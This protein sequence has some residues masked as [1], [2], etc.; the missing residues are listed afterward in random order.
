VIIEIKGKGVVIE[1]SGDGE[2][3][4][5]VDWIRDDED[6]R[7]TEACV[8]DSEDDLFDGDETVDYD[9][10]DECFEENVAKETEWT[11]ILQDVCEGEMRFDSDDHTDGDSGDE[12]DSE[13]NSN[14]ENAARA[15]VFCPSD[16]FDPR[17][18]LGMKFSHKK[19]FREAVHSHAI[20]TRRNLVITKNDKRRVYAR[21]KSNGCSWHINALKIRDEL[22]FQIREYNHVHS[23]GASFH[24]KNVRINWLS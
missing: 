7:E 20:M 18:A 19:E 24:V 22:G 10:D 16:T 15:P 17:F 21:C 11:G 6:M 1:E 4:D 3:A 14:E 9:E 8:A 5:W 2:R 12:F 13:K 23:C